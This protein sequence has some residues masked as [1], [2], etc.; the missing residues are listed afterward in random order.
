[1]SIYTHIPHPRIAA[2]RHERPPKVSDGR[3]GF[4]G[5]IGLRITLIVGTM[6]TAYI[7]TVLALISLP[8]AFKSGDVIIIVAWIA[9]TFLQLV[10]LPI[11]IVGQNLQSGASDKRATQTY[12]D[13]EAVLHE[14]LQIQAHLQ[15]QDSVLE[16][17]I[18]AVGG[19][20]PPQPAAQP[21][22]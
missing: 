13:A 1:M 14:C 16:R 18:T 10:L 3:V 5:K 2:R 7:F 11:I 4:N 19:T 17:L 21:G 6:W 12:E 8:A 22:T 20:P 9:Q 15:A